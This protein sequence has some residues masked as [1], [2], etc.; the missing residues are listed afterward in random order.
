MNEPVFSY[1]INNLKNAPVKGVK[2][3]ITF[4]RNGSE[5]AVM[6]FKQCY[7]PHVRPIDFIEGIL[8]NFKN[9]ELERV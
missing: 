8:D 7:V 9:M 6:D 1:A 4:F 2:Y 3:R 5:I